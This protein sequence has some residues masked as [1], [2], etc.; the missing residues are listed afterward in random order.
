MSG[1][2]QHGPGGV[3]LGTRLEHERRPI[4]RARVRPGGIGH[5]RDI[6]GGVERVGATVG[7]R[8]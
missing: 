7:T 5:S 1:I 3:Q 4:G 6:A 2:E 8:P